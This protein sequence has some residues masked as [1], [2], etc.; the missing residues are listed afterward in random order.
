[1]RRLVWD[2]SFRRAFRRSTRR[3]VSLREQI[4][5]VLESLAQDPFTP[6]LRTH[7][8][9]G[10]LADLWACWVEYDCRIVFTFESEPTGG[11]DMIVLVDI[12]SH[13]E[14]Y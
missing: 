8:L 3:N 4:L 2:A 7:K 12:G 13:D 11:E 6:E 5:V 9:K 14:V 10:Q 1:M